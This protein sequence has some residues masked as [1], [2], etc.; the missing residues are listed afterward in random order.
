MGYCELFD[1]EGRRL[2]FIEEE[3]LVWE[4]LGRSLGDR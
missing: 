1:S 4:E 3:E 2:V